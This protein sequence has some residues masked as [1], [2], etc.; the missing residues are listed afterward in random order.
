MRLWS[1]VFAKFPGCAGSIE[2]AQANKFHPINLIVPTQNFLEREFGF[3]VGTDGARLHRFVD[4]QPIGRPKN[5]A[6]RRKDDPPDISRDHGIEQIQSIA[7]V[8]PKI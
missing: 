6:G 5:S 7:N 1:M 8:I 2:V 4:W 3:A